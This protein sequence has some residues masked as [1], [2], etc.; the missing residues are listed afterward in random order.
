[1]ISSG[2][3]TNAANPGGNITITAG[4]GTGTPGGIDLI[5][6]D[7][8]DTGNGSVTIRTTSG[9]TSQGE[10][11][12]TYGTS[13]VVTNAT[14]N[15]T[16]LTLGTM[17]SDGSNLKIIV[18]LTAHDTGDDSNFVA[19]KYEQYFYR[20]GGTVAGVTAF[21]DQAQIVGTADFTSNVSFDVAVAGDNILLRVT[22][23]GGSGTEDFTL[24]MSVILVSQLGGLSS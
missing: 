11:H 6:E 16:V 23:D 20:D 22:N 8:G 4:G 2:G 13:D 7:D 12:Y 1:D 10:V 19:Y 24:D 5:T 9:F 21:E 18:R 15:Q 3:C 14:T 17:V